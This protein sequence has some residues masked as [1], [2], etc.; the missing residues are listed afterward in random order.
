M[1]KYSIPVMNISVFERESV[2][3]QSAPVSLVFEE[4]KQTAES[5]ADSNHMFTIQFKK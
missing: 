1:K 2:V 5:I 4:A 3:T